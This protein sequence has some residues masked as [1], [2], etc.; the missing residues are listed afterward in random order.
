MSKQIDHQKLA[1]NPANAHLFKDL[2]K[3]I[4]QKKREL[5]GS[6]VRI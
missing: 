4:T 1:A 3:Q 2:R 6:V 5:L